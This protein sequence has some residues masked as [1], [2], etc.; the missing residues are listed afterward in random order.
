[1]SDVFASSEDIF[2]SSPLIETTGMSLRIRVTSRISWRPVILG[3]ISSVIIKWKC[4]GC[5]QKTFNAATLL[6]L[7]VTS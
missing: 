2:L 1:M 6:V 5:A 3:M 4:C 7:T